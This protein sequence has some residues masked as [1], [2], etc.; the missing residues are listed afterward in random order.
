M[1][2]HELSKEWRIAFGLSVEAF[3]HGALPIGCLVIDE[4]GKIISQERARMVYGSRR[5][6]ITQHA[7]M[8]ALSKVA[9][10]DLEQR[11][12]L[13]TTIE[14]CPMCFGAI[15]VARIAE[16]H[17]GTYDPWAGSTNLAGGNWYMQRKQIDIR[18]ADARFQQII[19]LFLVYAMV[20]NGD[21]NNE[22]VDRWEWVV[23]DIKLKIGALRSPGFAKLRGTEAIFNALSERS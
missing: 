17:F 15:N 3:K 4:G 12:T 11:L 23:P 13:Y 10:T 2:Y 5:S 21:L 18:P 9:V 7:E 8:R 19:A 14:P 1:T 22:F 20:R 16:L 6:N